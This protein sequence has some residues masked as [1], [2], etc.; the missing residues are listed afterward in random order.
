LRKDV[1]QSKNKVEYID[2]IIRL[3][4]EEEEKENP[5]QS[6]KSKKKSGSGDDTDPEEERTRFLQRVLVSKSYHFL[7]F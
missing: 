3:I 7:S 5:E 6:T 1:I 2:S 4:K